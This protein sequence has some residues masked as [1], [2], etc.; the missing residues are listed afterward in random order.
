MV[1]TQMKEHACVSQTCATGE[2]S[3]R[4]SKGEISSVRVPFQGISPDESISTKY[5]CIYNEG[6]LC[7]TLEASLSRYSCRG[8]LLKRPLAPYEFDPLILQNKTSL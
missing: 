7:H 5:P 2:G 8:N 1:T 6:V 4:E 3:L